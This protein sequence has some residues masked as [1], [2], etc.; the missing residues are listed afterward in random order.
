MSLG[1][2]RCISSDELFGAKEV[3]SQEIKDRYAALS[4]ARA[5]SSDM[6]FGTTEE[7]KKGDDNNNEIGR[8]SNASGGMN[9][10]EYK[11]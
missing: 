5:I 7:E 3:K 9:Y 6:M 11:E 2:K 4:G 10:D 8:S 1:N